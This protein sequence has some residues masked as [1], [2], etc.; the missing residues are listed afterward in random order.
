MKV[1]G[2]EGVGGVTG[3]VAGEVAGEGEVMVVGWVVVEGEEEGEGAVEE[4][5]QMEF[6]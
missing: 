1:Q 6:H 4:E 5:D 3:E 2:E